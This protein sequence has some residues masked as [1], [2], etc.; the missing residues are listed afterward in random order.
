MRH[1]FRHEHHNRNDKVFTPDYTENFAKSCDPGGAKD[2]R[3]HYFDVFS[4]TVF[5]SKEAHYLKPRCLDFVER[6]LKAVRLR[7]GKHVFKFSYKLEEFA[8]AN[9]IP[10]GTAKGFFPEIM[11]NARYGLELTLR[12]LS[13]AGMTVTEIHDQAT[14]QCRRTWTVQFKCFLTPIDDIDW[15]RRYKK[16]LLK[17]IS[18]QS[19]LS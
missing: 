12:S 5:Y 15:E 11:S 18:V 3:L 10:V 7:V 2:T 16:V 6:T 13:R 1:Q 8:R 9:Q 4:P 19:P 17:P 14:G